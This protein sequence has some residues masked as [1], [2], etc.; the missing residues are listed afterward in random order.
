VD[1]REIE[2]AEKKVK[3]S[4]EREVKR[5]ADAKEKSKEKKSSSKRTSEV[6]A[7]DIVDAIDDP[8]VVHDDIV[9]ATDALV[10]G[11]SGDDLID[12]VGLP[13]PL[14]DNVHQQHTG[15]QPP[16][17]PDDGE[18][19]DGEGEEMVYREVIDGKTYY[20]D[21]YGQPIAV[22]A[23]ELGEGDVIYDDEHHDDL[24]GEGDLPDDADLVEM[25]RNDPRLAA[26][27]QAAK[28]IGRTS[29]HD[30]AIEEDYEHGPQS[31]HHNHSHNSGAGGAGVAGLPSGG[32]L[33]SYVGPSSGHGGGVMSEEEKAVTAAHLDRALL[34]YVG[35]HGHAS[36]AQAL[37]QFQQRQAA[38][39]RPSTNNNNH[40]DD[41]DDGEDGGDEEEP[42]ME[43]GD[44]DYDDEAALNPRTLARAIET[45]LRASDAATATSSHDDDDVEGDDIIDENGNEDIA[46]VAAIAR[47]AASGAR[48]PAN[49]NGGVRAGGDT[50][51]A[52]MERAR[53][54]QAA[55]VALANGAAAAAIAPLPLVT[56]TT[57]ATTTPSTS[58]NTASHHHNNDEDE[59]VDDDEDDEA[60]DEA[61]RAKRAE[62]DEEDDEEESPTSTTTTAAATRSAGPA[63]V[64]VAWTTAAT[65]ASPSATSP[66]TSSTSGKGHKSTR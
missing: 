58:S 3:E 39:M 42:S 49:G 18:G 56:S 29:G 25:S 21:K 7:D 54:M 48:V 45:Q 37:A 40:H 43:E 13:H 60:A 27:L 66:T 1:P 32:M 17:P 47:A 2:D 5:L 59:G 26:V 35:A 52:W 31:Q 22:L 62:Q 50:A 14:D 12:N 28:V 8:H 15:G 30:E 6:K 20:I 36:L 16:P 19:D 55:S 10:T 65:N 11:V 9:A 33:H 34:A 61:R 44:D 46:V 64:R 63:G 57:G 51:H 4:A 53:D 24:A 38:S 41:D 23:D